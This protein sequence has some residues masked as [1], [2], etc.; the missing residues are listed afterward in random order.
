MRRYHELD[1]LI[2]VVGGDDPVVGLL[3]VMALRPRR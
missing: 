2:L 1:G 3:A